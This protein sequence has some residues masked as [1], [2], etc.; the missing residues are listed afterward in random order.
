MSVPIV[1]NTINVNT[2]DT[3]AVI[4][5]GQNTQPNWDAHSKNNFGSGMFFGWNLTS[6]TVNNIVDN[7]F[8]DT[9]I[10]DNDAVSST[11]GQAG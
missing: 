8:I 3:N 5:V 6:H 4:A 9:P 1:F 11:Q 7:D 10:S 2:L